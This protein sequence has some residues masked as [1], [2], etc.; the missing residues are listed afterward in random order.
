M[1]RGASRLQSMELKELNMTE[2]THKIYIKKNHKTIMN[3][4]NL[5]YECKDKLTLG[6]EL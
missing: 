6:N 4:M 5:S 2:Q 1:G 3:K